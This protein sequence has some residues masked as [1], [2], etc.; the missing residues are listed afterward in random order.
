MRQN[1]TFIERVYKMRYYEISEAT[2]RQAKEMNSFDEYKE[3]SATA[4]YR[5]AVDDVYNLVDVVTS[6]QPE[7]AEKAAYLADKYARKLAEWVNKDNR[8]RSMCPS[9]MISGAGNFPVKKKQKQ[10]EATERHYKA[11]DEVTSIKEK[12]EQLQYPPRVI[13][14]DDE[15]ALEKLKEKLSKAEELQAEMKAVNAYY[16]K[17]KTLKGYKDYTDEKA[18]KLDEAIKSSMYGVPFP[19]YTLTNNNAKIKNTRARISQLERLKS[20]A[21]TAAEQPKEEYKTDLFEVVENAELMRLQLIFD[22][23][24]DEEIR[25]KLKKHGFKWS[26]KNQAWQRQLTNNAKYSLERLIEELS[27]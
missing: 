19:S 25:T 21:E 7:N 10:N 9:V 17:H 8:I 18:A 14:S 22:G 24:P 4:A 26:P 2:A 15:N 16:R 5:K 6:K 23:K 20:E 13:K 3:G 1:E 12:I 27:E 11:L